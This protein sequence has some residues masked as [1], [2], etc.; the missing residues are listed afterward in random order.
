VCD[1]LDATMDELRAKGVGFRGE[2]AVEPWGVW[3][4]MVL[5]GSV[6]VMLYEPRHRTAI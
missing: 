6:Q 4:T 3:T 2:P 1:D 5:P